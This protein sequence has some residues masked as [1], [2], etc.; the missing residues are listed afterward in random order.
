M[1]MGQLMNMRQPFNKKKLPALV[2]SMWCVNLHASSLSDGIAI[3]PFEINA[4][5]NR[6]VEFKVYN[7]TDE[8]YIVTQKVVSEEN[9][10]KKAKIPFVVNPPIRLLRK[11]SDAAM[12][13][14][15]L[16]E[17]EVFDKKRKYYL[18]VSFIPKKKDS[19]DLGFNIIFTQQIA[20]K[21]SALN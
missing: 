17:G 11:R 14:I 1:I 5:S 4:K 10:I 13:I 19:D 8:D 3:E 2:F 18:S 21:L 6:F 7:N 12:G 16:N 9:S 20:V 15:Y